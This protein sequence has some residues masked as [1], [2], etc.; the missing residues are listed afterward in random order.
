MKLY[1]YWRSSAAYRVRIGLNLKDLAVEE[2]FVAL[3]AGRQRSADYLALNPQGLVPTLI[4]GQVRL[5]QSLAILEYLDEVYPQPA[6][7]PADPVGR[8]RVRQLAQV[9]ACDIHP[10]DNLKVLNYLTGILGVSEDGRLTW[11]RHWVD[12]GLAALE[13]LVAH[14]PGTG[15]FCHGDQPS[16][17]DL[18]LVPQLYNARRFDI[19]LSRYPTLCNIDAVCQAL[20]AFAKAAPERQ[21]DAP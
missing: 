21:P 13:G 1:G 8:A 7:L 5:S 6:L 10:I 9:V 4:D 14:N 3:P 19:D 2:E 12:Q 17:A 15:R 16:L 18:C 11:Y 20:D